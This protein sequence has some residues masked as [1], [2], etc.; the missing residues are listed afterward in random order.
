MLRKPP[1]S[2]SFKLPNPGFLLSAPWDCLTSIFWQILLWGNLVSGEERVSEEEGLG[3]LGLGTP[4]SSP[5]RIGEEMV[6]FSSPLPLPKSKGF[7]F[8]VCEMK[9]G[10][11]GKGLWLGLHPHPKYP[12]P[13]IPLPSLGEADPGKWVI[14]PPR[15]VSRC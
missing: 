2:P 12:S 5:L 3:Q 9:E 13:H 6:N 8:L 7:P 10:N 11:L 15:P 1:V 14:L 4:G